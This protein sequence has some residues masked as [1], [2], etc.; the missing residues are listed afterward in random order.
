MYFFKN[1]VIMENLLAI[2]RPYLI[3]DQTTRFVCSIISFTIMALMAGIAIYDLVT[4]RIR[5]GLRAFQVI[6]GIEFFGL[7]SV[8]RFRKAI[9]YLIEKLDEKCGDIEEF[10]PKLQTKTTNIL[11][12]FIPSIIFD[13]LGL[14]FLGANYNCAIFLSV[15]FSAHDAEM[16]FFSIIVE[17]IN[18]RLE[19]L[20]SASPCAASRVYRHVLIAIAHLSEQYTARVSIILKSVDTIFNVNL[21][22]KWSILL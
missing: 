21:I 12:S 3:E 22:L 19:R 5:L 17:T 9:F 16:Y 18:M 4:F 6:I 8:S 11:L 2:S 13:F 15:A 1:F 10:G 20:K 7:S 14:K